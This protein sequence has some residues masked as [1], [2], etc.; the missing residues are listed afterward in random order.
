MTN[1]DMIIKM[2]E[3][4]LLDRLNDSHVCVV[5]N[6]GRLTR[7]EVLER[8]EKY[9]CRKCIEKFLNEEAR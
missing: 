4:D 7:K 2:N 8:C 1:Y 3:C 9:D 5:E 6:L